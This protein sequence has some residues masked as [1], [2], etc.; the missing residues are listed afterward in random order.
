MTSLYVEK[1]S[2]QRSLI[3]LEY[4]TET[5]I[6]KENERGRRRRKL[7][8]NTGGERFGDNIKKRNFMLDL[9]TSNQIISKK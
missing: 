6:L 9:I 3:F 4:G 5:L 2:N 7:E 8:K 1:V